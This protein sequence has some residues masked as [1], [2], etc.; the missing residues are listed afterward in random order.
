[1]ADFK[2]KTSEDQE[3]SW[4]NFTALCKGCGICIEKCPKKALSFDSEQSGPYGA[5]TVK[6]DLKHCIACGICEL[7]CPDHAIRV[8][9]K[10]KSRQQ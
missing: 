7:H 2:P 8:D 3:K 1:L 4:T 10:K 6:C 9:K 5:P